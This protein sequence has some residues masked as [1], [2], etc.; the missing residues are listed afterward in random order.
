MQFLIPVD[1][2]RKL[3]CSEK[4]MGHKC[5]LKS[6]QELLYHARFWNTAK[7]KT[8]ESSPLSCQAAPGQ[9]S[10]AHRYYPDVKT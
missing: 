9:A 2:R 4:H 7:V 10:V 8:E 1:F 3:G 5:L 6:A